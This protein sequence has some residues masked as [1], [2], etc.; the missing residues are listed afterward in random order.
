MQHESAGRIVRFGSFEVDLRERKLTKTGSRIRLQEQPFRILVMLLERPGQLVTREEIR[1]EL[2]PK[3]VFVDF[4]AALNTAVRKLRDALSDAADN[5]R[6]LETVPRQ[7]YR[8]L[9]PVICSSELQAAVPFGSRIR[10]HPYMLVVTAL[11]LTGSAVG[12][13]W[14]FRGRVSPITPQDT[15]VLADFD[16]STGDEIFDGTLNTALTLSLRQSPFFKVLPDSD[17]ARTLQQMTRPASTK[18][19]PELTRELCQ[20]AGSKAYIAGSIGSLGSKYVLGLK[21]V[22]CQNGETLAQEQAI[23]NSKENVLDTLGE[24][25]SRVRG[26]LGES[27]ASVQK[28][29]VPLAHATTSSL[30]AL[31]VYSVGLKVFD[32]KGSSAALPYFQRAI[33]LDP[34]FAIGYDELGLEYYNLSERGRATEYFSKA[35]QLREQ[36][37][38]WEKLAIAAD[39]YLNATGELDKAAQT[40]EQWIERYPR[41]SEAYASLG[42]VYATQ[43]QYDKAAEVTSQGLRLAPS[44]G[45]YGNLANYALASQRFD[46]A[47]RIVH[48]AQSRKMDAFEFHTVLYALAFLDADSAATAE[49][50]QWFAGKPEESF[51][52]ALASDTEAYGGHLGMAR[53]L[54]KQAVDSAIRADN[55]ESGAIWLANAALQQAAYGK[56][57]EARQTAAEALKLAPTSPGAEVEAALAFAM[58]G[59]TTRAESLAQDLNKR[60]PLDTQM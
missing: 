40:Y 46:D 44:L 47:R 52:L 39:Y 17:V 19:T 57:A 36:T 18:L 27:L 11:I 59:N 50:Q 13:F 7:G 41:D 42:V 53:Q 23:A 30:E 60:F 51:G 49:Q 26:E 3:D 56:H 54:T 28:F 43:G 21:A 9:A 33:D 35:F 8:F 6:F 24:A 22:N 34:N 14:H 45:S 5:P 48:E 58:A 25:A 10:Q 29:D 2:W 37:G 4:D 1:Q 16:N 55:K 32:Q 15:I 12:G 20:R 38:E 31:K